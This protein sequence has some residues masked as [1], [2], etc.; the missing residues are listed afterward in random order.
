MMNPNY[1]KH[2]PVMLPQVLETLAPQ[3]NKVYVDATF[4]NGGYTEAI[5]EKANC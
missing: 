5:L 3:D 2:F 1:Q 4:G